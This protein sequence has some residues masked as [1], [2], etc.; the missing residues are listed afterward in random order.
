MGKARHGRSEGAK[1]RAATPSPAP[2][3]TAPEQAGRAAPG[4]H[5]E[6]ILVEFIDPPEPER[7]A[8]LRRLVGDIVPVCVDLACD[9]DAVL[10]ACICYRVPGEPRWRFAPMR[11]EPAPH[12]WRGVLRMQTGGRYRVS[13][14]AWVDGFA[15]VR[16]R[17]L[18]ALESGRGGSAARRA[19]RDVLLAS[20][21]RAAGQDRELLESRAAALADAAV[22]DADVVELVRDRA[23]AKRM[24]V[25]GDRLDLMRAAPGFDVIVDRKRAGFAAWWIG[26]PPDAEPTPTAATRHS[27]A[28]FDVLLRTGV[29]VLCLPSAH[30]EVPGLKAARPP[31][32]RLEADGDASFA[33]AV[34]QARRLGLE[35][36]LDFEV[37]KVAPD[38]EPASTTAPSLWKGDRDAAWRAALAALERRIAQGVYLF[39]VPDAEK[40][41]LPF[42]KWLVNRV[43]RAHPEVVMVAAGDPTPI[44][45]ASLA[46]AGLSTIW[47]PRRWCSADALQEALLLLSDAGVVRLLRPHLALDLTDSD[48]VARAETLAALR[49]RLVLATM[50]SPTC[51]FRS[52]TRVASELQQDLRT[53]LRVRRENRALQ[54]ATNVRVQ[55][56]DNPRILFVSRSVPEQRNDVFVIVNL[57]TKHAQEGRIEVPLQDL[58]LSEGQAYEIEDLL[59]RDRTTWHGSRRSVRLDPRVQPGHVLRLARPRRL[60]E[61]M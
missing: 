37:P 8:A 13:V 6:R 14:E 3:S 49:Q 22:S 7:R 54:I 32:A 45:E 56:C 48:R 1:P 2:S 15:T 39:R 20:S 4:R 36:A 30:L 40:Q 25:H 46:R 29:D 9:G 60:G 38:D 35:V 5:F 24:W 19:L 33:Q 43:K 61:L 41:P 17:T 58:G 28:G 50:L 16:Q 52:T 53:L 59:T 11:R 47:P 21:A 57:D 51:S 10:S 18:R 23:L 44:Q 31:A 55:R 34:L 27:T 26:A 12:R 42:W